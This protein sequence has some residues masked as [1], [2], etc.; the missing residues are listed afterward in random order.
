MSSAQESPV[1]G[2]LYVPDPWYNPSVPHVRLFETPVADASPRGSEP[3]SH[4]YGHGKLARHPHRAHLPS[5]T[6]VLFLACGTFSSCNVEDAMD[7][8]ALFLNIAW[9]AILAVTLVVFWAE[10]VPEKPKKG[11]NG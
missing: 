4:G 9:M 8:V 11:K 5:L 7:G 6:V 10:K 2:L 3:Y 1:L